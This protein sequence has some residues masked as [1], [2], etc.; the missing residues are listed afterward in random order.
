MTRAKR[1]RAVTD[2]HI[3]CCPACAAGIGEGCRTVVKDGKALSRVPRASRLVHAA[4]L[5]EGATHA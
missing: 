1:R 5:E 3:R 2:P 4:R